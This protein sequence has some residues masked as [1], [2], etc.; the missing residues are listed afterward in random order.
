[1]DGRPNGHNGPALIQRR[2]LGALRLLVDLA[3]HNQ[4]YVLTVYRQVLLQCLAPSAPG[5]PFSTCI[6]I[7]FLSAKVTWRWRFERGSASSLY[8]MNQSALDQYNLACA[9]RIASAFWTIS[10]SAPVTR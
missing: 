4:Q 1:M 7:S 6:S 8:P 9:R 3:R 10:G 5:L 2:V